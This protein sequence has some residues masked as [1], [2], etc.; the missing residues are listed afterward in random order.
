MLTQRL[1]TTIVAIFALYGVN[2]YT[3]NNFFIMR[4]EKFV[5]C[6]C[7]IIMYHV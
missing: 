1:M 2:M 5:G 7:N 6:F 4:A 3:C